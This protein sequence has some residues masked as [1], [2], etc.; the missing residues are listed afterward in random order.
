M[1]ADIYHS[2]DYYYYYRVEVNLTEYEFAER[3]LIRSYPRESNRSI[4]NCLETIGSPFLSS[5]RS[6]LQHDYA[7]GFVGVVLANQ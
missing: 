2:Y 3:R 5:S 1:L 4:R 7:S 6:Q